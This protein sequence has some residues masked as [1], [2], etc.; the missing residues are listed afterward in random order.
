MTDARDTPVEDLEVSVRTMKWLLDQDVGTV[1]ELLALPAIEGPAIVLAELEELFEGLELEYTGEWRHVS[2]PALLVAE[3]TVTERWETIEEWLEEN[4]P[5]ALET[6]REPA[7]FAEIAAAEAELGL[8][9]PTEY[10]EFLALHD[11]QEDMGPMVAFCSLLPVG[12]L[13][14]ERRELGALLAQGAENFDGKAVDPG[15]EK[16][17]WNPSWLPIGRF[18]R[19]A[20]ILD[21]APAEGGAEGQIFLAYVDDDARPLVA[22]SF[23]ELLGRYF[24]ELQDGTIDLSELEDEEDDEDEDEDDEDEG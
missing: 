19:D 20:L 5:E 22:T 1:G 3:G 8:A 18:Q 10:K 24:R 13:A 2:A 11:G 15:I 12:R 7:T 23:G 6:F 16:V 4:A 21:L 9:L 17:A 14:E